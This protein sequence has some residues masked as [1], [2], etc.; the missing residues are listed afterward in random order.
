MSRCKT[1]KRI[2]TLVLFLFTSTGFIAGA[3]AATLEVGP[4]RTYTYPSIAAVHAQNGDTVEIAAG[5][6]PGDVAVW[7]Q[8]NLTIRGVGGKAILRAN[9]K[10]AEGKGIW[11]IKG[12]NVIVDNIEFSGAAVPDGNGAGI[13]IEGI[14]LTI[15]NSYF[16]HN[17]NGVLGGGVKPADDILIES[18][19]F[20]YNGRGDGYTHNIYI[21]P[22]RTLTLKYNYIH[23]AHVGH[24]VKSRAYRTDILH[25]RIMDEASGDSSYVVDLPNGGLS[26]VIGNLIQQGPKAENPTVVTYGEE[27]LRNATNQLYLL[28]NTIVNDRPQGGRF[29]YVR[30]G[31]SAVRLVN[32]LLIGS[33]TI[34]APGAQMSN[35]VGTVNDLVSAQ[36]YD[37]HLKKSS[38]AINTGIDPGSANGIVLWATQQ[39]VHKSGHETRPR[40]GAMDVGAYEFK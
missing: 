3:K 32:N 10:Y 12:N 15:R 5:V 26:Y 35:M 9:G 31:A 37:Y 8:N 13:R 36:T 19:E 39:Y 6:Y 20:A 25:N 16:H 22:A 14:D 24:N 33:G 23:H 38:R 40:V 28:N 30:S 34:S 11:V 29:V 1:T 2:P 18:S 17:E 7:R 21:G 27:G 4:G